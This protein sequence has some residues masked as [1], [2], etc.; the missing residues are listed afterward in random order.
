MFPIAAYRYLLFRVHIAAAECQG[1]QG[2]L[3]LYGVHIITTVERRNRKRWELLGLF[4]S[5]PP[6]N[7]YH[8]HGLSPSKMEKY[9]FVLL[10]RSLYYSTDLNVTC[11]S[12]AHFS[13]YQIPA[14]ILAFRDLMLFHKS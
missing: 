6:T 14:A 10:L 1:G 11:N 9:P 4:A 13:P 5:K 7:I 12:S 2:G 3:L 8:Y